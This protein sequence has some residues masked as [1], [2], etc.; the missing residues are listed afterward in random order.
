MQLN[1]DSSFLNLKTIWA[2][3]SSAHRGRCLTATS[4]PFAPPSTQKLILSHKENL[5][6]VSARC[7]DGM[8]TPDPPTSKL[9]NPESHIWKAF[10]FQGE[11]GLSGNGSDRFLTLLSQ[12][13]KTADMDITRE[14]TWR[15]TMF[16]CWQTYSTLGCRRGPNRHFYDCNE[17]L[18][19]KWKWKGT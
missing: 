15:T 2:V 6:G 4:G 13:E 18:G 3:P 16:K 5:E 17:D 8:P 1:K 10:L 7:A 19:T 9:E 12:G 14:R 11:I